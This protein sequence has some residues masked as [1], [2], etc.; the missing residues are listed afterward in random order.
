MKKTTS[1]FPTVKFLLPSI[2]QEAETFVMFLHQADANWQSYIF[3]RH[4][5]LR[6][7]SGVDDS[8]KIYKVCYEYV[9]EF[10]ALHKN[11]LSRAVKQ[12]EKLWRPI[13]RKY[14]QTLSKHFEIKFPAHRKM[15]RAY[16]S[17]IPVYPR[18][19][20]TWSFNVSY[21]KPERVKEIACHEIQHF[22][23][24]KKWIQVFP[25]TKRAELDSP[26]LVWRLSELIAPVILNE[27][28][29]FRTLISGKQTTYE[30]FQ[31]IR[32]RG[33]QPT[34]HLQIMYRRHLKSSAPFEEFLKE[35]WQFARD[36]TKIL[37][38]A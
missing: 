32:I 7:L 21:F 25:K 6:E 20:D 28:P 12:N 36:N 14:L 29:H 26:H 24:F 16:V 19:I 10:R 35:I 9:K 1:L 2:A 33:R 27:H 22:L 31:K 18:W 4:P 15:M 37:M 34:T 3:S 23:Y 30:N 11:E 38:A 8:A 17:I 5:K 13:E